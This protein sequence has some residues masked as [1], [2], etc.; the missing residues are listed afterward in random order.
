MI[1]LSVSSLPRLHLQ[2]DRN[3]C[4]VIFPAGASLGFFTSLDIA[5]MS[6][7]LWLGALML[8]ITSL[9]IGSEPISDLC[10]NFSDAPGIW[11]RMAGT[12]G[13]PAP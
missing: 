2:E 9:S 4:M 5:G 11:A 8:F 12:G 10:A 6:A 7:A 3:T 1:E 13:A